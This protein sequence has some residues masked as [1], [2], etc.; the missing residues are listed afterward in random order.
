M[1]EAADAEGSRAPCVVT[2]DMGGCSAQ[3][4]LSELLIGSSAGRFNL[5]ALAVSSTVVIPGTDDSVPPAEILQAVVGMFQGRG[6]TAAML[7]Q[8]VCVLNFLGAEHLLTG[9]QT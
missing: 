2:L 8:V 7:P 5:A 6:C 3:I 4:F 9:K 1:L